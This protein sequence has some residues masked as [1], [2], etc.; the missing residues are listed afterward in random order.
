[1]LHQSLW[2][3]A[4]LDLPL[5]AQPGAVQR[6][7]QLLTRGSAGDQPLPDWSPDCPMTSCWSSECNGHGRK[8][9]GNGES[10]YTTQNALVCSSGCFFGLPSA[11]LGGLAN[12]LFFGLLSGL[13]FVPIGWLHRA[14]AQRLTRTVRQ[15]HAGDSAHRSC[16]LARY[17][18]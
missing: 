12:G 10:I 14:Q 11:L 16:P 17:L 8:R 4:R 2:Q 13:C 6:P 7:C 18:R 15:K 9:A 3:E 1:V 5:V